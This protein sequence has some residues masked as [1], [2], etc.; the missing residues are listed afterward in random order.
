[1]TIDPAQLLAEHVAQTSYSALPEH[2]V[3]ATKRD[4][5]DTLG[6]AIGGSVAP[7]INTLVNMVRHWGGR[8]ESSL[9]LLGDRVPSPQAALVNAAMGHALDFDDTL[10]RGGNIHPGASH[11]K[12]SHLPNASRANPTPAPNPVGRASRSGTEMVDRRA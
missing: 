3:T 4:I 8:E 5:L 2:A 7:G 6:A 10:D 12:C 1:M 9:L 11:L